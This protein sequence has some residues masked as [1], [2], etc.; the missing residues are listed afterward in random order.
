MNTILFIA[1][2]CIISITL[3]SLIYYK[4][5]RPSLYKKRYM[6]PPKKMRWQTIFAVFLLHIFTALI[7]IAVFPYLDSDEESTIL[8]C[9]T[10][11]VLLYLLYTAWYFANHRLYEGVDFIS[12][13]LF[14]I[15]S[16]LLLYTIWF[17]KIKYRNILWSMV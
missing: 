11:S 4:I 3:T 1:I 13:L 7:A 15:V 14:L 10:L 9:R 12:I 5:F 16:R 8:I 2:Y 17:S 6:P